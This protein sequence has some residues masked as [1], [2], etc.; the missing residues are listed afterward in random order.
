MSITFPR[1]STTTSIVNPVVSWA[2]RTSFPIRWKALSA[3]AN[4]G[5]GSL[6]LGVMDNG[7]PDGLQPTVGKTPVR[8]WVEQK[9]PTLL[10]YPLS[11]FRVHLLERGKASGFLPTKRSLS[12]MSVTVPP[13]RTKASAT[14]V[15]TGARQDIPFQLPISI[16]SF[17]GSG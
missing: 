4:S 6:I 16:W 9:V 17:Y 14:N 15:I 11:D 8:E 12:L 2:I 7:T 10:D 1:E 3:F 13:H 5:G